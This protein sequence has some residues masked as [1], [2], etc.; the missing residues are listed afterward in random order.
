MHVNELK[1]TLAKE[2]VKPMT[3][4]DCTLFKCRTGS[5]YL[6][7]L[8]WECIHEVHGF[9]Q[10]IRLTENEL[11]SKKNVAFIYANMWRR[12]QNIV[13]EVLQ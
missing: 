9:G 3:L 2:Y 6:C 10:I 13:I 12:P 4:Y 11:T 7:M 8:I 1:H 5:R